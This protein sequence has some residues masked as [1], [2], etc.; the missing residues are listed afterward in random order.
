MGQPGD[1]YV[2]VRGLGS[3]VVTVSQDGQIA[4]R[5]AQHRVRY[6]SN[7]RELGQ[8]GS[9]KAA[10]ALLHLG[11]GLHWETAGQLRRR[12]VV[13]R[14]PL[15]LQVVDRCQ[16]SCASWIWSKILS[17]HRHLE[18]SLLLTLREALSVQRRWM[19]RELGLR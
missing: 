13:P 9:E 2:V 5:T 14:G 8:S 10:V 19:K 18:V 16:D 12:V 15:T 11:S 3:D 4:F 7:L 1:L 6:T 17:R